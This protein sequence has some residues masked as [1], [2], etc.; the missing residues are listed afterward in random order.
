MMSRNLRTFR[1]VCLLLLLVG[2]YA[3]DSSSNPDVGHGGAGGSQSGGWQS[4]GNWRGGG[5]QSGG[6]WQDGG[7]QSGGSW[8]G[9]WYSDWRSRPQEVPDPAEVC[10]PPADTQKMSKKAKKKVCID[11]TAEAIT[12]AGLAASSGGLP[13]TG[14]ANPAAAASS[15]WIPED[16][17]APPP[18]T[19]PPPTTVAV[20]PGPPQG[21]PPSASSGGL[22][23]TGAG[24]GGGGQQRRSCPLTCCLC[25]EVVEK[26]SEFLLSNRGKGGDDVHG[27]LWGYCF[28]CSEYYPDSEDPDV[29]AKARREFKQQS[30]KA[31]ERLKDVNHKRAERARSASLATLNEVLKEKYKE[32]SANEIRTK[33]F[34]MITM[35]VMRW[36]EDID[37]LDEKERNITT[38]ALT[39]IHAEWMKDVMAQAENYLFVPQVSLANIGDYH[40]Y[41]TYVRRSIFVSFA[42]RL[43]EPPVV[44]G[45]RGQLALL[46]P[47]VP[48]SIPRTRSN[49]E[50]RWHEAH[51]TLQDPG[52]DEPID[53]GVQDPPGHL[54][55]CG[56]REVPRERC[57]PVR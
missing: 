31:F 46:L 43:L 45:G 19:G 52:R 10:A 48:H 12:N 30:K 17:T 4:D 1:T 8:Q 56:G 6:N 32:A 42:C 23:Q 28:E 3:M 57:R 41:L 53:N 33:S 44:A 2:G 15:T 37:E 13:Q 27:R 14:T 34:E 36:V 38:S 21:P 39:V 24:G 7:W 51:A 11:A 29:V 25:D 22:P 54:A 55:C 40:Q 5:W 35:V 9:G 49:H 50:E 18:P 16:S 26:A 47:D 20:P